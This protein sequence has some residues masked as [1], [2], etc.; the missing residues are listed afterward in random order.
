MNRHKEKLQA[1]EV[2]S[3]ISNIGK[4]FEYKYWS[5]VVIMKRKHKTWKVSHD[6]PSN[7]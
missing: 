6:K 3:T 7:P 2:K 5:I 4:W 1:I